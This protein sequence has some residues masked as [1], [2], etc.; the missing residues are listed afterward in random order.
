VH[1][2]GIVAGSADTTASDLADSLAN[3]PLTPI[4]WVSGVAAIWLLAR[5]STEGLYA[6]VLCG[7]LLA[8]SGGL[9][10]AA[11]LSRSQLPFGYEPAVGRAAVALTLGLGVGVVSASLIVLQRQGLLFVRGPEPE[12]ATG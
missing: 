9:A 12:A 5:G 3:S 10:D 4:G 6:T 7:L 8:V 1:I 11:Y 2:A